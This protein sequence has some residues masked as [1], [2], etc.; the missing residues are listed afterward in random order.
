MFIK[1]NTAVDP[2][3]LNSFIDLESH[4][5]QRT[6]SNKQKTMYVYQQT[7]FLKINKMMSNQT[8]II[9]L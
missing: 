9:L 4:R 7:P 2:S 1:I 6:P 5:L 8:K 3:I